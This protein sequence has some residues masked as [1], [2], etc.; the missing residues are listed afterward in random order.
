[1]DYVFSMNIF[2]ISFNTSSVFSI[3]KLKWYCKIFKS[4]LKFFIAMKIWLRF[5][6]F[7]PLRFWFRNEHEEYTEK[8]GFKSIYILVLDFYCTADVGFLIF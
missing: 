6:H 4:Q 1:M 3:D 8:R 2:S 5:S 7:T